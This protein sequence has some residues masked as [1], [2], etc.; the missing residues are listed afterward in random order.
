MS[1]ALSVLR[2]AHRVKRIKDLF[3]AKDSPLLRG[4]VYDRLRMMLLS[5]KIGGG[6]RLVGT[7]PAKKWK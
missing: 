2:G 7:A 1:N 4:E 5:G 3:F 6:K